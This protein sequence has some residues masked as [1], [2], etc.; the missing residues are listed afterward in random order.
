MY[1]TRG[2]SIPILLYELIIIR[3]L[4]HKHV[5]AY[6]ITSICCI[7]VLINKWPIRIQSTCLTHDRR[8]LFFYCISKLYRNLFS[9]F[10]LYILSQPYAPHLYGKYLISRDAAISS[11][12]LSYIIHLDFNYP[13]STTSALQVTHPSKWLIH[14]SVIPSHTV[15]CLLVVAEITSISIPDIYTSVVIVSKSHKLQ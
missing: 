1:T 9:A 3:C 13:I 8:H 12:S 5:F 11:R 15:V 10:I 14:Y 2:M 7:N 4:L 6:K